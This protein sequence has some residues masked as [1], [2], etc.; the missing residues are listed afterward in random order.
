MIYTEAFPPLCPVCEAYGTL[1]TYTRSKT[2][3]LDEHVGILNSLAAALL[4]RKN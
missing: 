4:E 1:H 3:Y 2:F